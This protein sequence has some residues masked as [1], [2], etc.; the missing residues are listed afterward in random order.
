MP[1]EQRKDFNFMGYR[2]YFIGL[3]V[4][5]AIGSIVAFINPGPRFGT[6]FV[7]GTEVTVAF[8]SDVDAGQIRSAIN[9]L[10]FASPDVV[11]LASEVIPHQYL[12]RVKEVSSISDEQRAALEK[13]LCLVKDP[14]AADAGAELDQAACPPE[15]RTR[16]VKFSP[17]GDKVSVRY[18][19]RTAGETVSICDAPKP[20]EQCPLKEIYQNQLGTG[21]AG[22]E[23][24]SGL[25]NPVVTSPRENQIEF[26]FKGKGEQIMDGLRAKLGAEVVPERPLKVQWIGAKA[27]KDLRDAAIK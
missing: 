25:E 19:K 18:V 16:E 17:G 1:Q 11:K 20:N 15:L 5:L 23:L 27:G 8:K 7:G 24:R 3:S 10:G 22:V 2:R 26:L 13:K 21:V 4:L 6:D 12:I 14:T 9:D